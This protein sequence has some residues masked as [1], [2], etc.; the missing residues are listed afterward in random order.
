MTVFCN[1]SKICWSLKICS[2]VYQHSVNSRHISLS[3]LRNSVKEDL[4]NVTLHFEVE[5]PTL[6][7]PLQSTFPFLHKALNW[8][9]L[10]HKVHYKL[11]PQMIGCHSKAWCLTS[12]QL[13]FTFATKISGMLN[14]S[15]K[16]VRACQNINFIYNV[17]TQE[18][19]EGETVREVELNKSLFSVE[20]SSC[21]QRLMSYK[22]TLIPANQTC[23]FG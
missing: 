16:V 13:K 5:F 8:C 18:L 22:L 17:K 9:I 19:R 23:Y 2:N 3:N 14:G 7:Y 21:R 4:E 1:I 20:L 11:R 12:V 15:V 6:Q 10:W